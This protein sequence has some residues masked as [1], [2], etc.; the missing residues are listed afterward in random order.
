MYS[1]PLWIVVSLTAL[2]LGNVEN[3][4][5]GLALMLLLKPAKKRDVRILSLLGLWSDLWS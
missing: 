3:D 5:V 4:V 1:M 2:L